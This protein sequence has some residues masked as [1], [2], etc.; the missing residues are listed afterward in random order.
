[1]HSLRVIKILF[2]AI[3]LLN[4]V[5]LAFGDMPVMANSPKDDVKP[6]STVISSDVVKPSNLSVKGSEYIVPP[7]ETTT[8]MVEKPS[9]RKVKGEDYIVPEY[10]ESILPK[11]ETEESDTDTEKNETVSSKESVRYDENG[12][13][14]LGNF[15]LTSYCACSYCCGKYAENRP[16]D[17]NGNEIILTASGN[18][19][20]DGLTI[21]VDPKVIPLGST[22]IINGHE[23]VA[24]DT[25]G[26]VKGN[27]IDI[28]FASHDAALEFGCHRGDVYLKT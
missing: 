13:V 4:I 11:E 10:D 17:E 12:N 22:V 26:A 20:V 27:V 9:N 18:R 8:V 15:K 1:M 2:V 3:T 6:V 25:G 19:A 5:A 21:A 24:M 16:V 7:I 23:Y 14:Y 28:Y